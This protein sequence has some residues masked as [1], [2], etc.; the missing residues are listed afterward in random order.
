M[1]QNLYVMPYWAFIATI[2]IFIAILISAIYASGK[3]K[4]SKWFKKYFD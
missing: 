1:F 2:L 3:Y 4:K